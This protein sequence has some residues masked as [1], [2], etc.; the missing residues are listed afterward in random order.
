MKYQFCLN[1]GYSLMVLAPL[2]RSYG[3]SVYLSDYNYGFGS[4]GL[5]PIKLNNRGL[6]FIES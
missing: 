5:D 6:R 1:V 4:V 3:V 2:W